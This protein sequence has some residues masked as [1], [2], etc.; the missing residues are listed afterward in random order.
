MKS[1]LELSCTVEYYIQYNASSY[2]FNV[3]DSHTQQT[4][5]ARIDIFQR[6]WRI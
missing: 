5:A 6:R 3:L 1:R 2:C 4:I